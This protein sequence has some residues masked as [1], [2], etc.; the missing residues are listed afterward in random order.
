[1]HP[2]IK[3]GEY[4]R[5]R[6]E[7]VE[8]IR[9]LGIDPYGGVF[10][11]TQ[12][13][14]AVRDQ[15]DPANQQQQIRTAGR[16][17]LYRDIGKLIFA[18][19]RESTGSIQIGL[20]KSLLSESW[21]LVKLLDLGDIVGVEGTLGQTKTGEIT[22]W[23]SQLVLL[24]KATLPPPEKWHGLQD[25]E[26]RYRQRYVDLFTNPEVM[27]IFQ[28]RFAIV[29]QIR[30]FFQQRGFLEV[31]TPMM[32]PVAGGA[33]ARPFVTHHNTLDMDLYLRIAPELYLK[34]L[35][36]GGIER[37]FEI[38]RNFRNEGISTQ[39]N[40][41]FTMCEV[42][43]AYA[44]YNTMMDLMEELICSLV[45]PHSEDMTLEFDGRRINYRQPWARKTYAE[46]LKEHTGCDINDVAAIRSQAR[47]REIGEAN[48]DDLVV[49]HELFEKCVEKNL[50]EPTFVMDYPAAL[51]PLTK[52]KAGAEYLAERFELL[53]AGMEI[54]N[55]YTELNNPAVQEENLRRQLRGQKETMATMDE[56]FVTAL[57][58]GMPP[59]GGL[60]FGVDRLVML[61]TNSPCIRDVILFPLLRRVESST[62]K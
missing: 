12:P 7:K 55:A 23:V 9:Q 34:R 40:P 44:D 33:A 50:I 60:G 13:I 25:V 56:D 32:H 1:M 24:C 41:E 51:C 21:P 49:T 11:P 57:K 15:Y 42:Y 14:Q 53:I 36:V 8:K 2:E 43:Q 26:I 18:T 47:Q 48:M 17:I 31:E 54:A 28:Q 39:H 6:L 45:S 30:E 5:N 3:I 59:A 37:V 35:L 38:N 27:A 52:P 16:I 62:S 61:L 4:E 58:Y 19:L 29:R 10:S 20:S 46:L 22:I